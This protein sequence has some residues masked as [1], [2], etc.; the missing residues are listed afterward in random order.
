MPI[1]L[2]ATDLD[3][4]LLRR[5]K[6]ISDY[7]VGV[8]KRCRESGILIAFATSRSE[9]ASQR[10]SA[11][12]KPDV[13]VSNGGSLV[14]VGETVIYS[15]PI[16]LD[17]THAIIASCAANPNIKEIAVETANGYFNSQPIDPTWSGWIDYSHRQVVDFA[18]PIDYGEVYK[19]SVYASEVD[20][21][22]ET[23]SK[24]DDMDVL[25]WTGEDWYQIKRVDV[26]KAAG[27]E[28]VA[29]HLGISLADIVAF[30]DD[31]ND[32]EMLEKCG[33][34]VVVANAIDEVKAVAD[35]VCGDCDDD[36]V[37]RWIEEGLL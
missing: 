15:A 32:L 4:T 8:F 5:D 24:H 18:M 12:I 33:T 7:T 9:F 29:R 31:V 22:L 11:R 20:D 1:K 16:P 2:I 26:N 30:G 28:H 35:Y 25:C 3:N 36:G 21:V 34:G 6:T 27:L 23:V 10:F 37:A 14:R 17:V 19:I 13:F